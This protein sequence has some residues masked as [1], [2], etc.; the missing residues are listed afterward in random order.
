MATVEFQDNGIKVTALCPTAPIV[1]ETFIPMPLKE[2]DDTLIAAS[3]K[4]DELEAG[5]EQRKVAHNRL[6]MVNAELIANQIGMATEMEDLKKYKA[7]LDEMLTV[8]DEQLRGLL[9]ETKRL[10]VHAQREY[11]RGF[12]TGCV[13]G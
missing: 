12:L 13:H 7:S 9:E 2:I 1:F 6:V 4:I 8:R 11:T 5:L 3:R 10:K